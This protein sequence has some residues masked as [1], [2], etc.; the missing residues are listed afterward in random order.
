MNSMIVYE[1]C[2]PYETAGAAGIV[3]VP[4]DY[5][6]LE[7]YRKIYNDCFCEMRKALGIKPVNVYTDSD[8]LKDRLDNICI[9]LDNSRIIGAVSCYGNEIDDLM[10]RKASQGKGYGRKLL[11]WAIQR[12]R[13]ENKAPITLHVAQW[14]A[15][16]VT[17]YRQMGFAITKK[18]KIKP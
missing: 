14:N 15:R 18:E 3:C 16:A 6:Y 9:L 11:L 1:M 13:Q 17:L 7:E 5:G 12:I 2:Y 10:V 8:D 4:L